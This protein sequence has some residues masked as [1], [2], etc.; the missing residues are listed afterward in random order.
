MHALTGYVDFRPEER[1]ETVAA[2]EAVT[3]R[4]R[5]DAGCVDYWWSED[6]EQTCRFRFFECWE[7]EEAFDAHQAQPYEHE[8]MAEHLTRIVGAAA[9]VFAVADRRSVLAD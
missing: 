8:F 7:S 2:L 9:H 6:L 4:S 3:A 5:G 1:D